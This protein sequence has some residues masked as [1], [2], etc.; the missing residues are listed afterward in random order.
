[1]NDFT[2]PKSETKQ[3]K[4]SERF[5]LY[6]PA[7][8]L[9]LI[10]LAIILIISS[11]LTKND[12]L[13]GFGICLIIIAL[14]L[15]LLASKRTGFLQVCFLLWLVLPLACF[16]YFN[17]IVTNWRLQVPPHGYSNL[18]TTEALLIFF[19]VIVLPILAV[20]VSLKNKR[21]PSHSLT[22]LSLPFA[23][24][25]LIG[26]GFSCFNPAFPAA[27]GSVAMTLFT[28][29]VS[30]KISSQTKVLGIGIAI[31]IAIFI[32]GTLLGFQLHPRKRLEPQGVYERE[33]I[34]YNP[35]VTSEAQVSGESQYGAASGYGWYRTGP[36]L[37]AGDDYYYF[38]CTNGLQL[39]IVI[40][41]LWLAIVLLI[42]RADRMI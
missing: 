34:M 41:P 37:E 9:G 1:M 11:A 18:A 25:F 4:G 38:V 17:T 29:K 35:V 27:V 31:L 39:L 22:L 19:L 14:L 42:L 3:P 33:G 23:F 30:E 26:G 6:L 32:T 24:A 12:F 2:N 7:I 16:Y 13:Q 8:W 10:V 36:H 40:S 20:K 28:R 5:W 15:L 21:P